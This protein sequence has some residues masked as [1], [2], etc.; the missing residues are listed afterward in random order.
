MIGGIIKACTG[1][2]YGNQI[3]D[4][5]KINRGL[6]HTAME[7]GGCE[8]HLIKLYFLKRENISIN[9]V[10]YNACDYL[11]RGLFSLRTKFGK[12]PLSEDA[13][14]KVTAF[15]KAYEGIRNSSSQASSSNS[16]NEAL[17]SDELKLLSETFRESA[18][19]SSWL[20]IRA[21]EKNEN[22][23]VTRPELFKNIHEKLDAGLIHSDN[24]NHRMAQNL[25]NQAISELVK[26]HPELFHSD[27][28]YSDA[29]RQ[30]KTLRE[31]VLNPLWKRHAT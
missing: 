19:L 23:F 2:K 21:L 12:Q 29:L 6:F 31:E 9:E 20:L 27:P 22:F 16:S 18:A 14:E 13:L 30:L 5:L 3:A 25:F 4:F 17:T 7:E 15:K 8:M 10:A 26:N 28:E 11:I 24:G 1:K